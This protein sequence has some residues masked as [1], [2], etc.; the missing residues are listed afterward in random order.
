LFLFFNLPPLRG[1]SHLWFLFEKGFAGPAK[2]GKKR[3]R[4]KA[5]RILNEKKNKPFGLK[6]TLAAH[7][8]FYLLTKRYCC[9]SSFSDSKA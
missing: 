8:L 5:Q 4:D 6:A 3:R 9:L 1:N 2:L 7:N